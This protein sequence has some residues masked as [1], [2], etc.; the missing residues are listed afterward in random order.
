MLLAYEKRR[1]RASILRGLTGLAR[2]ESAFRRGLDRVVYSTNDVR[3]KL[4]DS[5]VNAASKQGR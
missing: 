1:I 2:T 3:A 4:G 5:V